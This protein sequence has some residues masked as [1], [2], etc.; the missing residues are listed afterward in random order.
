[1]GNS[2]T[3]LHIRKNNIELKIQECNK[4]L[5]YETNCATLE[6]LPNPEYVEALK[7]LKNSYIVMLEKINRNL[8]KYNERLL[9]KTILPR[10]NTNTQTE[11]SQRDKHSESEI[12]EV[13]IGI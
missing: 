5:Y 9:P 4:L 10:F 7:T 2:L 1:M 13:Q 3:Q 11:T 6:K 12:M 8:E